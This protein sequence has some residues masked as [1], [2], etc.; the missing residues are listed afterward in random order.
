M[1]LML[2]VELTELMGFGLSYLGSI[3]A[4]CRERGGR[5]S[6]IESAGTMR[7][8]FI[9]GQTYPVSKARKIKF[10]LISDCF[11]PSSFLARNTKSQI[12]TMRT[13]NHEP[14]RMNGMA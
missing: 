4:H 12:R 1:L 2:V 5:E 10:P 6:V 8:P 9:S 14:S 7:R 13:M 3:D 11:A